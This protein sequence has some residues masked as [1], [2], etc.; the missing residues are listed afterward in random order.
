MRSLT[1]YAKSCN[2]CNS[3]N[4]ANCDARSGY[5]I[6]SCKPGY[7]GNGNNCTRMAFCDTYQCCPQ[8]YKWDIDQKVCADINECSSPS[9]NE[10]SPTETCINRNGI[11]L[12]NPNPAAT[13]SGRV[14]SKDQD[15]LNVGQNQ[16][17]CADPCD[18]YK[19]KNGDSRLSSISSSGRFDTDRYDFGWFRYT[20]KLTASLKEGTVGSLKCGSLEPFSLAAAHP[21]IGDGIT[22]VPLYSNSLSGPVKAGTL[23]VK[24]C[25]RGYYVY[26]FSGSLKFDVYCT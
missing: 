17:T 9:L 24:A 5:V 2:F 20:G 23:P 16:F 13:C 19:L 14:C 4:N 22:L 6:C 10:C 21:K 26:K 25:P 8:G 1:S 12:C 18:W 15:C 3:T 11:Y 7:I